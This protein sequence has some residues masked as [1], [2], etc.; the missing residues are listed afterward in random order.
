MIYICIH[1][2]TTKV[3]D[4]K[5]EYTNPADVADPA[6]REKAR[7][8]YEQN[9]KRLDLETVIRNGASVDAEGGY[10]TSGPWFLYESTE[11]QFAFPAT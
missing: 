1:N 6:A 10:F 4:Y 7:L 5:E 2:D 8:T 3:I 11:A 9:R